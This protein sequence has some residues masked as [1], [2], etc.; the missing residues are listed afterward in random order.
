MH[1]SVGVQEEEYG[2]DEDREEN[3]YDIDDGENDN[4]EDEEDEEDFWEMELKKR[5]NQQP[6]RSRQGRI[7]HRINRAQGAPKRQGSFN[8]LSN[9][10][11]GLEKVHGQ[12]FTS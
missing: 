2:D 6:R 4:I 9:I 12:Y 3:D 5:S 1:Y 11:V 8:R 10:P 7:V